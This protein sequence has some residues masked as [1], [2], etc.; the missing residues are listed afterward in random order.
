[1]RHYETLYIVNPELDDENYKAV[2]DKFKD[3]IEK[4][5]GVI[6]KLEEWGKQRLA[7]LVKKFNQG[8]Y[9]LMDY[10]GGS[11]ITAELERD[12]KLDDR[13]LKY[14][15]VKLA[16]DVEPQALIQKEEE[17]KGET[18]PSEDQAQEEEETA[19]EEKS[20]SDTSDKGVNNG[21]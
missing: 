4:E 14:Q 18:A 6:V 5:K 13:V 2:V 3:L 1:M 17:A 11:G 16:D 8:S 21:V 10:C 9:V 15:T 19:K 20:E 7:Y 12:L